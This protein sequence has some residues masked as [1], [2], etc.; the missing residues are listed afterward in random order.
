MVVVAE[1][2]GEGEASV[3]EGG[4]EGCEG[5]GD[6]VGVDLVA[7]EDDEVG[8]LGV[9]GGGDVVDGGAGG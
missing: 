2:E 9:E 7:G 1:H 8:L 5:F 3:D 6:A 4:C